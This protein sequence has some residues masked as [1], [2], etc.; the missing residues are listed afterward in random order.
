[1][2]IREIRAAGLRGPVP[3]SGKGSRSRQERCIYTLIAVIT[4]EGLTGLGSIYTNDDL[5]K[6]ALAV[7]APV[8]RSGNMGINGRWEQHRCWRIMT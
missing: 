6:S 8:G 3:K 1:M 2:R 5:V 4:D 7:L